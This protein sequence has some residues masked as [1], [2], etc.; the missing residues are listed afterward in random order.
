MSVL[1]KVIS[2]FVSN[3]G[4]PVNEGIYILQIFSFHLNCEL[5]ICWLETPLHILVFFLICCGWTTT[6]S[7][8]PLLSDKICAELV[9][10]YAS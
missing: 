3:P 8:P 2:K 4:L 9:F 5:L 7:L 1:S 10:L 6:S